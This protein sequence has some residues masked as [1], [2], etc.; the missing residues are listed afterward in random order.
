MEKYWKEG[1]LSF[2]IGQFPEIFFEEEANK[3]ISQFVRDKIRSRVKDPITAEKLV[4]KDYGF[5]T[6][7]V[8]LETNYYEVYNQPNVS[9]VDVRTNAIK[10]RGADSY[11]K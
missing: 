6:R 1:S 8:P 7:R 2:W 3:E 11:F 4:P 5:G 10:N 9:L